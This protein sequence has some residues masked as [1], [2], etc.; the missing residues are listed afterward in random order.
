MIADL[1]NKVF[2]AWQQG[3]STG[4]YTLFNSYISSKFTSF[5]HP[6]LGKFEGEVALQKLKE[7]I[8]ERESSPNSLTFSEIKILS[9]ETFIGFSFRSQGTVQGGKFQYYGFN[10]IVFNIEDDSL[11]GFSEFFGYIDPNW[12]K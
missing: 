11:K 1:G 8:T 3:E 12:F 6:L 5:S 10:I 4:D 9:N 2:S 7:L